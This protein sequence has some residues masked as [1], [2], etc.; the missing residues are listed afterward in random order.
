[1]IISYGRVDPKNKSSGGDIRLKMKHG[2]NIF[3]Q[4]DDIGLIYLNGRDMLPLPTTPN[5]I[6]SVNTICLNPVKKFKY[7]LY[8]QVVVAGYGSK[9]PTGTQPQSPKKDWLTV[10]YQRVDDSQMCHTK[11]R[12][13]FTPTKE[14]CYSDRE[15]LTH[16][17]GGDSGSPVVRYTN[18]DATRGIASQRA[19]LAGVHESSNGDCGNKTLLRRR[20]AKLSVGL[21]TSYYLDWI[22]G[23]VFRI[24]PNAVPVIQLSGPS[25]KHQKRK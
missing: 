4:Q 18:I 16:L 11:F 14:F 2:V 6:R 15:Y 1:M 12:N 7:S 5:D 10:T 20:V 19:I 9:V 23:T 8:A 24:N 13:E 25:S 17:C 3:M 22:K 21:K